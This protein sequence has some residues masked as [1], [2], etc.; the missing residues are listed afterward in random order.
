MEREGV[1]GCPERRR[2]T[3]FRCGQ[4]ARDPGVRMVDSGRL[5]LTHGPPSIALVLRVLDPTVVTV[6][7]VV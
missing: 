6:V 4:I 7:G 5:T 2:W 1:K 3:R